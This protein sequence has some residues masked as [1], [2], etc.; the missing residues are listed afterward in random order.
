MWNTWSELI[1]GLSA[2]AYLQ[3][4][5]LPLSLL[6]AW[7]TV[8]FTANDQKE[9]LVAQETC[10]I[11]N[12]ICEHSKLIRLSYEEHYKG[13]YPEGFSAKAVKASQRKIQS[14]QKDLEIKRQVVNAYLGK[15]GSGALTKAIDDWLYKLESSEN[16]PVYRKADIFDESD[17][18][19]N[20]MHGAQAVFE[21]SLARIKRDS[22]RKKIV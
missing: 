16:F 6:V 3:A 13:A 11:I 15:N 9:T 1:S 17:S 5:S 14:L 12:D 22:L 10:G 21:A 19:F 18:F 20:E 7:L 4:L 2:E 8:R